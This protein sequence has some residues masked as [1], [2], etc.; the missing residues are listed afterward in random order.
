MQG[1]TGCLSAVAEFMSEVRKARGLLP[2]VRRDQLLPG[3]PHP[4]AQLSPRTAAWLLLAQPEDLTQEKDRA[5]AAALPGLHL[6]IEQAANAAQRFA[7]LV[8]TRAA[9]GFDEWLADMR[10]SSL[11]QLRTF[12]RSLQ[13][14]YAAVRAALSLPWSNGPVEGH[15]NHLKFVKRQMFGRAKFDLLRIR[16]LTFPP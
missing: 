15:V 6:D 12:A 1:Y 10:Q 3:P 2:F 16:V 11:P 13:H 9:G 8:R 7:Q 5:L 4:T 14:D